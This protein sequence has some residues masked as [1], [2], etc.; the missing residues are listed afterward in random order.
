MNDDLTE[1]AKALV[2]GVRLGLAG[3]QSQTSTCFLF[4]K[5][6]LLPIGVVKYAN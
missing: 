3:V 1:L 6:N 4:F 2:T 5:Y